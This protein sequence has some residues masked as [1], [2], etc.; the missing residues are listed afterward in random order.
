MFQESQRVLKRMLVD[1]L[2]QK[3][4]ALTA[5]RQEFEP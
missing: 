3:Q 2:L 5:L 1:L 4:E